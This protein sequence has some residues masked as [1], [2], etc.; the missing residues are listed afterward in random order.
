MV[1]DDAEKCAATLPEPA[2]SDGID[3][4]D[5]A[6]CGNLVDDKVHVMTRMVCGVRLMNMF[7][8]LKWAELPAKA[9]TQ[10]LTRFLPPRPRRNP[11]G[12]SM[13]RPVRVRL[14][15]KTFNSPWYCLLPALCCV[16][17]NATRLLELHGCQYWP[18]LH[19][20][21]PPFR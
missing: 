15:P 18:D 17:L 11:P 13:S 3:T 19:S 7:C 9:C 12:A 16:R 2:R 8:S 10:T 1:Q 4:G 14:Q 20:L 6:G 21:V 5:R